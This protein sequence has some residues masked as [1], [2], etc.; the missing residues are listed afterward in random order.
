MNIIEYKPN[1]ISSIFDEFYLPD[2]FNQTF[3]ECKIPDINIINNEN[4][5]SI[6]VAI[7]GKSKEN[8][9]VKLDDNILSI[10]LDDSNEIENTSNYSLKQFSYNSF[11]RTFKLPDDANLGKIKANYT[12]GVLN[13]ELPKNKIKQKKTKE[14][15]I[16]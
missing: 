8:F 14:I 13:V 5:Y 2:F 16:S 11:L 9:S 12:N 6:Q 1:L 4:L 3:N 15:I 10:S 7:P